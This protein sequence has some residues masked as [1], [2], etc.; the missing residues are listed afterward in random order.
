MPAK[1]AGPPPLPLRRV[2]G[3]FESGVMRRA[4][5]GAAA[6]SVLAM[7]SSGGAPSSSATKP[8]ASTPPM[9]W[10]S[11]AT[12]VSAAHSSMLSCF[13]AHLCARRAGQGCAV[14][15]TILTD[16]ANQ[17]HAL[18][19]G[20]AGYVYVNTDDCAYAERSARWFSTD[21]MLDA[22]SPAACTQAGWTRP[23]TP[24]RT[25]RCRQHRSFPAGSRP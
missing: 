22:D 6:L 7:A 11:W 16:A 4:V 12:F 25:S 23:A 8:T 9:G 18:G 10:N 19:L 2:T 14:N 15:E 13:A 20:P 1:S 3:S 24:R 17:M 21:A 5:N